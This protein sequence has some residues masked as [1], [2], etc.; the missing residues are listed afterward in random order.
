MKFSEV[1]RSPAAAILDGFPALQYLPDLLLPMRRHAKELHKT[2][3][4]LYVGNYLKT[5]KR[6]LEGKVKV[7]DDAPLPVYC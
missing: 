4:E 2:E 6:V 7:R 1:F 3:Y 5:K